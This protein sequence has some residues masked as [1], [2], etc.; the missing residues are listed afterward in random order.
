MGID[1]VADLANADTANIRRSFSVVLERTVRELRGTACIDLED[2][3][4]KQQIMAS[5]SFGQ[6]LHSQHEIAEAVAWH[7][8][9]A[10]EKLRAQHSVAGAVYVFVQTNRFREQDAQY[11]AGLVI[12]LP[13][14]TDDTRLLTTA[15][16]FG[17]QRIYRDGY[18]YKKCG[19]MLMELTAKAQ[20]QETLFDDVVARSSSTKLMTA[21]DK[22]NHI[23]GRGTLRTGA[24]G[25]TQ[26]WAMRSQNSSPRYTTRWDELPIAK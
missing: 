8:A 21:M 1:T 13:D 2:L 3:E 23:W 4:P 10:A 26:Q 11:N 16:L 20:R 14:V 25:F 12:P 6:M 22:I 17:L 7:V 19:V 15:A 18:A 9:T 24:A 5:R